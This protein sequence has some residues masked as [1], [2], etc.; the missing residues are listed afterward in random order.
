MD[1]SPYASTSYFPS[2]IPYLAHLASPLVWDAP[3]AASSSSSL[4]HYAMPAS[5]DSFHS[6]SSYDSVYTPSSPLFEM[7]S[8]PEHFLSSEHTEDTL[9]LPFF[10]LPPQGQT[11]GGGAPVQ[12]D[13]GEHYWVDSSNLWAATA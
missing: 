9:S 6:S 2:Q 10:P 12:E 5:P 11:Y 1:T 3:S 4:S 13:W 8:P 7:D